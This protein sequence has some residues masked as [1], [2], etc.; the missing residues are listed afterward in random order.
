VRV[1]EV[2]VTPWRRRESG[3]ASAL[4]C[5]VTAGLSRH[6]R[7]VLDGAGHWLPLERTEEVNSALLAFLHELD[8]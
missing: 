7:A 5:R 8:T 6:V 1:Q 3:S 4:M 2:R